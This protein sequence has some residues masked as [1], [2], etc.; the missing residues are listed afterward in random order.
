MSLL[1]IKLILYIEMDRKITFQ[2][3]K[4]HV[5]YIKED[6]FRIAI[7]EFF[8]VILGRKKIHEVVCKFT[9]TKSIKN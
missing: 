5:K 9:G 8:V 2:K 6:K 4:Y 1:K 3:A 7:K